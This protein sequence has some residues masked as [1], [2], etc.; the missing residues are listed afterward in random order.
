MVNFWMYS[1]I[2]HIDARFGYVVLSSY[3]YVVL[4]NS[5]C[6]VLSTLRRPMR[7]AVP[8]AVRNEDGAQATSPHA[9]IE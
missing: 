9:I 2:V 1:V 4:W 3:K 6:T 8:L 5:R 7:A